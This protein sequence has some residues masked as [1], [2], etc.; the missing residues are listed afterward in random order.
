MILFGIDPGVSGGIASM[1]RGK[2]TLFSFQNLTMQ[3][4]IDLLATL[5]SIPDDK[6]VMLE[7]LQPLPSFLRG[8]KTSW[9]LSGHYHMLKTLLSVHKVS[10]DEVRPQVWQSALGCITPKTKDKDKKVDKKKLN[11]EK[12]QALFPEVKKINAC[13]A[14][15]LLIAEYARRIKHV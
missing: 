6:F 11:R 2:V 5:F 13:T 7:K 8:C 9:I 10:F 14:D 4:T 1:E 12:A 15:A 3:E